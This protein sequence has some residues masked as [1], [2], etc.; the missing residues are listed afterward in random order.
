MVM[1]AGTARAEDRLGQAVSLAKSAEGVPAAFIHPQAE[2]D[3]L[4]DKWTTLT[5]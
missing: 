5:G 2:C 1:P 4:H 3:S